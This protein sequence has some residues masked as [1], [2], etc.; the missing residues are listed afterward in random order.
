MK[1]FL[2]NKER[3]TKWIIPWKSS[4]L[5]ILIQIND[6]KLLSHWMRQ[7]DK[8]RLTSNSMEPG[9]SME[10]DVIYLACGKR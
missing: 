6:A 8:N 4:R 10:L 7:L 2:P 5:E 1:A 3:R 9:N